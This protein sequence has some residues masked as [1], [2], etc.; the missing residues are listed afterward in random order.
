[1][2]ARGSRSGLPGPFAV[3]SGPQTH[4][5]LRLGASPYGLVSFIMVSVQYASCAGPLKSGDVGTWD[6]GGPAVWSVKPLEE[7]QVQGL[8]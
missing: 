2:T 3:A 5:P 6:T 7:E 8:G 1:M 4:G